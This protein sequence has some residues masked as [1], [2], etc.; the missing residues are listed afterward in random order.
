MLIERTLDPAG[1]KLQHAANTSEIG[2]Y[3]LQDIDRL[4]DI[5]SGVDQS[6]EPVVEKK[7]VFKIACLEC[8]L[9]MPQ[10]EIQPLYQLR[11]HDP[12]SL[13]DKLGFDCLANEE[14][15]K[16]LLGIQP[17]HKGAVLGTDI[18]QA[19]I[20]QSINSAA[21]RVPG[22]AEFFRQK[23]LVDRIPGPNLA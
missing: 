23:H 18:N 19:V 7:K 3:M 14:T 11:F 12:R 16:D 2:L 13:G 22:R 6:V 5:D 21:N 20:G 8:D 10:I 9:L 15:V 17:R 1:L 4:A